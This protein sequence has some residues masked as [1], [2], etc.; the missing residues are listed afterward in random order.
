MIEI[1][2]GPHLCKLAQKPD[3]KTEDML[4]DILSYEPRDAQAVQQ[5]RFIYVNGK[6][7]YNKRFNEDPRRYLYHRGTRQFPTGLLPKVIEAL[8]GN[9]NLTGQVNTVKPVAHNVACTPRYYQ[10][11]GWKALI[12]AGRGVGVYPTG[13]GKTPICSMLASSYPNSKVLCTTPNK[14]LLHQ[15]RTEMA[16]FLG[17]PVGILGDSEKD[18]SSHVVV[19]TIQSLVSRCAAKDQEV[20]DF[21]SEVEVWICDESHGAAADSYKELSKHLPKAHNRYGLTATWI[22]EDGCELVMEG[23]LGD[24]IYTYTY[25]KAFDDKFL[26]PIRVWLRPFKYPNIVREKRPNYAS[27]YKKYIVENDERN[28]QIALDAVSFAENNMGPCLVMVKQIEHGK[29][30]AEM[31]D[32][33]FINGQNETKTVDKVLEEFMSGKYKIIVASNILNV[34][35]NLKELRSAIN[36]GGGDSRINS[37][38]QPGRGVR[39]HPTKTH[40]D[41]LDYVD[42]EPNF[43][44]SHSYNRRFTYKQNFPGRVYDI[45]VESVPHLIATLKETEERAS[46]NDTNGTART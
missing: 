1:I 38:Q 32:C 17:Y 22:R 12:E 45:K 19:A 8:G 41:Y 44:E 5:N 21:L 46:L 26:T 4:R 9:I 24:V 35:V 27:W 37:L 13:S 15:N 20:L 42:Y 7:R 25:E 14:R 43:F 36:A 23:V 3:E 29:R 18:L 6:A 28:L 33:P 34:G 16:K 10:E 31:I 40:F 11:E 30:L 2:Y 39:L